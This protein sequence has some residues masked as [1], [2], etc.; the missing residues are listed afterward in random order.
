MEWINFFKEE[1]KKEYY[2][3]L[4]DFINLEYQTKDIN[5]SYDNIFRCFKE[6]PFNNVKCVILGQDPYPNKR[7]ASG[8]AFSI[9]KNTDIPK[10]LRNIFIELHNDL[11]TDIPS[12][13]DLS[14]W[15]KEGVLLL[16]SILTVENNKS[17]SH[18]DKGWEIFTDNVLIFL[19]KY[20]KNICYILWG[21]NSFKKEK[22]INKENNLIIKSPHPSPLSAYKGFFNSKPFSRCNKYLKENNLKEIDWKL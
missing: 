11:D 21:N 12:N 17:L 4:I 8:L 13:G 6:T 14:K 15:S 18:K 22:F 10:S 9:N 1:E 19:N 16:N 3:K 7:H 2:K 5:P 20:K